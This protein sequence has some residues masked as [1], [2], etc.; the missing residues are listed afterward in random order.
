MNKGKI[1]NFDHIKSFFKVYAQANSFKSQK[2]P[3][4]YAKITS[5]AR[6]FSAC[7]ICCVINIFTNRMDIE[8]NSDQQKG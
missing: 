7:F 3:K 6:H 1:N 5:G 8:N 4:T 2:A